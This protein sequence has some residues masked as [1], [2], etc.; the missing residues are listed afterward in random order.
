MTQ[1][2]KQQLMQDFLAF[3][4]AKEKGES[5]NV[6]SKATPTTNSKKPK[7]ERYTLPLK[8][9]RPKD[10]KIVLALI[11][12]EVDGLPNESICDAIFNDLQKI[13]HDLQVKSFSDDE[14]ALISKRLMII[15][16]AFKTFLTTENADKLAKKYYLSTYIKAS[17]LTDIVAYRESI[18]KGAK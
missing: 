9:E 14:K 4:E 12:N 6:K 7:R 2:Q 8:T 17:L 5:A 15:V 11:S 16:G 3:M 13:D 10:Y 18:K 1:K